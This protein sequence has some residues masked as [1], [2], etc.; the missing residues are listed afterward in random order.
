MVVAICAAAC[1]LNLDL[2][3][4]ID[5]DVDTVALAWLASSASSAAAN[6]ST[7]DE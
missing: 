4:V 5:T 7:R 3:A 2:H 1:M 6:G